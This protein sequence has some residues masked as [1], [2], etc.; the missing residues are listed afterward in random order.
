MM[1][2]LFIPIIFFHLIGGLKASTDSL[3][4]YIFLSEDCPV[5]Q[6][7]TLPLRELAT[8]FQDKM[9]GFVGVFSNPSSADSTIF[10]FGAKYKLN[11]P[12]QFDPTQELAKKL[13]AKITPEVIVVNHGNVD[14][15]VY[16]GAVDNA[17]PA[18]GKRRKNVNQHYL[19]DALTALLNGSLNYI[20]TTEPVGC[21]IT[22]N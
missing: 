15:V 9:V 18:L 10:F 1:K 2:Y 5:C 4:V 19:R 17:Y 7:Q 14:A 13:D 20:T 21:Y 6:N 22:Y 11:F 12:T 16:R 3:T 8:Q